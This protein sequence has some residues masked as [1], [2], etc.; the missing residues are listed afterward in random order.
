MK[1]I[2]LLTAGIIAAALSTVTSAFTYR[3]DD[4]L[5][6]TADVDGDGRADLVIV[7]RPTGAYRIGYQLVSDVYTWSDSRPSGIQNVTS[8]TSGHILSASR[9]AIA[10]TGDSD[11]VVNVIDAADPSAEGPLYPLYPDGISSRLVVAL[12]FTLAPV[13][14]QDDLVVGTDETLGGGYR[15]IWSASS[16]AGIFQQASIT[17]FGSWTSADRVQ[18]G[19]G[20]PDVVG[21]LAK[22][23]TVYD[24]RVVQPGPTQPKQLVADL[25]PVPSQFTYGAFGAGTMNRF[26]FN[27]PGDS[28][29][30]V[31][32]AQQVSPGQYTLS[33]SVAFS[34]GF[35]FDQLQVIAGSPARLL[36][37]A[38]DGSE[39]RLFDFDGVSAPVLRQSLSGPAGEHLSGA[40]PSGSGKF[41]LLSA[42]DNSRRSTS[43]HSFKFDGTKFVKVGS[44]TLPGINPLALGANVFL[45]QSEPFVASQAGLVRRLNAADWSSHPILLGGQVSVTAERDR[46]VSLGLGNPSSRNLGSLPPTAHFGLVNQYH[47]LISLMSLD[48][49]APSPTSPVTIS[50]KPGAQVQAIQVSLT[51]ADPAYQPA[52]SLNGSPWTTYSGPFWLF[53]TTQVRYLAMKSGTTIKGPTSIAQYTFAS[54][55][56]IADSDGDGVPD[57]VEL[58]KGLDPTKGPDTDGDGF[59]DLNEILAGTN[60]GMTNSF[61]AGNQLVESFQSFDFHVAPRP[62]DPW[63]M[64]ETNAVSG[65]QVMVLDLDGGL[66]RAGLTTNL[67]G[68]VFDSESPLTNI[69]AERFPAVVAFGTDANYGIETSEPDPVVGRE[70]IGL[71]ST[72]QLDRPPINYTYGGGSLATEAAQWTAAAQAAYASAVHP[73]L[74]I[75]LGAL[76]TVAA[77]LTERKINQ[78]LADR[79]IAGFNATNLTLF[80]FRV[81]DVSRQAASLDQLNALSLELDSM[82]PGYDLGNLHSAILKA[83]KTSSNLTSVRLLATDIYRISGLSNNAAPGQFGQ[84]VDVLRAFFIGGTLL[85][86]YAS[87]TT[88]TPAQ[89]TAATAS[90]ATLLNAMTGRP[91]AEFDLAVQAN[92]FQ[93]NLTRLLDTSS[94]HIKNLYIKSGIAYQFPQSFELVPGSVVHVLAYTDFV[95]PGV[96][97]DS[98]QVMDATLVSAPP[99]PVASNGNGLTSDAWGLLFFGGAFDPFADSDGDGFSNL[100]E[101]LD[102]SDPMDGKSHGSKLVALKLPKIQL[103]PVDPGSGQLTLSFSFPSNYASAFN[104][105]VLKSTALGGTVE[106]LPLVP[107]TGPGDQLQVVLP[108]VQDEVGFFQVFMQLK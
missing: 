88:L 34:L 4:E 68:A 52:Y 100:Q 42:N 47:P 84:P 76:E 87:L 16:G 99:A 45:F 39:A 57:F 104:F 28:N 94:G 81:A 5:F 78:V 75:P 10:L 97:G 30:V 55:P 61:P 25:Q 41:Q 71:A 50:P 7:D 27:E 31:R 82:H 58:A 102:G 1:T 29:L 23:G 90:V 70:F 22:N 9:E 92:S 69:L 83:V 14:P 32:T 26:L 35:N 107:V 95:E 33:G 66:L 46:G 72:P 60:P 54:D 40:I 37:I 19:Q 96:L 67:A 36:A 49:I 12:N 64:K 106:I 103:S 65:V 85:D 89:I 105:T 86:P 44:S 13:T 56:S 20:L 18:L 3:T 53:K 59:S 8:V 77:L 21:L 51:V 6:L 62:L 2:S 48:P 93:Q 91:L 101:F 108:A 17:A 80:P 74:E 43:T 15:Q 63:L 38:S 11:N 73:T 98:L 79:G 24:F